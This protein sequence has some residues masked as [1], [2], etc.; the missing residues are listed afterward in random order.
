MEQTL[1]LGPDPRSSTISTLT[2]G[3]GGATRHLPRPPGSAPH[4]QTGS[5]YLTGSGA[6]KWQ[7]TARA[8]LPRSAE[9]IER[10]VACALPENTRDGVF[11]RPWGLGRSAWRARR[12]WG[13]R[14]CAICRVFGPSDDGGR[15]LIKTKNP[16]AAAVGGP[17]ERR[18]RG[19]GAARGCGREAPGRDGSSRGRGCVAYDTIA[20]L[21]AEASI[22]TGIGARL[23]N[24]CVM[25]ASAQRTRSVR[26]A[27]A[28]RTRTQ[29]VRGWAITPVRAGG[30]LGQQQ[31]TWRAGV[32]NARRAGFTVYEAAGFGHYLISAVCPTKG[33]NCIPEGNNLLDVA[34]E[35]SV[36]LTGVRNDGVGVLGLLPVFPRRF[37]LKRKQPAT[38]GRKAKTEKLISFASGYFRLGSEP[39]IKGCFSSR[40]RYEGFVPTQSHLPPPRSHMFWSGDRSR[41]GAVGLPFCLWRQIRARESGPTGCAYRLLRSSQAQSIATWE[42]TL[43]EIAPPKAHAGPRGW[44]WG[45]SRVGAPLLLDGM[46]RSVSP[47]V[48]QRRAGWISDVGKEANA[49]NSPPPHATVFASMLGRRPRSLARRC[50]SPLL[51][52]MPCAPLLLF[53]A[54]KRTAHEKGSRRWRL[55]GRPV[56]TLRW[57]SARLDKK[58]KRVQTGM[59][60]IKWARGTLT[61]RVGDNGNGGRSGYRAVGGCGWL[62]GQESHHGT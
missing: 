8:S 59:P 26:T 5:L 1:L 9:A 4:L 58:S 17:T 61:R 2:L 54:S 7:A 14:A 11:L 28:M 50:F 55:A 44:G 47:P 13:S 42:D 49:V 24:A 39:V 15:P 29:Q 60:R 57:L 37:V 62:T 33:G 12:V 30:F 16:A 35:R 20:S 10:F 18:S 23:T 31:R 51:L 46:A 53:L 21:T 56:L 48:V 3:E 25:A 36:D 52:I 41:S 43:G 32:A 6:R 45:C 22:K 27:G 19:V 38:H 34:P 40:H